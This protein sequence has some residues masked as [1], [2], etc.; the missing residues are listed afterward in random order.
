MNSKNSEFAGNSDKGMS[1][2]YINEESKAILNLKRGFILVAV[3]LFQTAQ[4]FS[5]NMS[6][7][8]FD[9]KKVV[10]YGARNGVLDSLAKNPGTNN[11][12]SSAK[13]AKYTRNGEK[14]FDNIK[15][16]LNGQLSGVSAFATYLGIP[17]KIKLKIYTNAPIGTLVEVLLG[18][19]G[20]NNEYPAGT[21]SQYQAH[22]TLTGAWEEL[23]F[24]FSQI[25]EGSETTDAEINQITLMFN[26]NSASTDIYYFDE[27]SGPMVIKP[28]TE[29][30]PV[31]TDKKEKTAPGKKEKTPKKVKASGAK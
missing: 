13:C 11:I 29:E 12:D 26:P 27:L 22:T 30:K 2:G 10:L 16:N 8:N 20:R 23:E 3:I 19:K 17:P 25:P 15:M 18:S 7:D 1:I 28:I 31:I 6:Y 24:K 21:H 4:V 9:G 14:K 5:Q